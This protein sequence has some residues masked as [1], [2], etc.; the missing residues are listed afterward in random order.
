MLSEMKTS[1]LEL[2]MKNKRRKDRGRPLVGPEAMTTVAQIFQFRRGT[3]SGTIHYV[4]PDG[5]QAPGRFTW[6][7]NHGGQSLQQKPKLFILPYRHKYLIFPSIK[8][9]KF[10][11]RYPSGNSS[12][13]KGTRVAALLPRGWSPVGHLL[14]PAPGIVWNCPSLLMRTEEVECELILNLT[15]L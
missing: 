15:K 3:F 7:C 10:S 2:Y 6:F 9:P 4:I 14:A 12:L 11:A 13:L 5:N 1:P 8:S